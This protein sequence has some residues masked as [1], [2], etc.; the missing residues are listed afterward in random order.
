MFSSDDSEDETKIKKY[1]GDSDSDNSDSDGTWSLHIIYYNNYTFID[2]RRRRDSSSSDDDGGRR[3]K[4]TEDPEV[5]RKRETIQSR[6]D[7]KKIKISRFR[8]AHWLH[9]SWF[10]R[11]I[12]GCY[13]RVN[14]GT[15]EHKSN[16][17]IAEI[18]EVTE[19]SKVYSLGLIKI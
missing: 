4:R 19:S 15:H 2:D 14:I 5:A 17:R 13:V 11:T 8:M 18:V 9:M 1:I 7:L 12:Q 16:Y 6:D 3:N 10:S